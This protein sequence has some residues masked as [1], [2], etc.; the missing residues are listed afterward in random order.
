MKSSII[1]KI[2]QKELHF[3]ISPPVPAD[4][5]GKTLIT[6]QL[7]LKFRKQKYQRLLYKLIKSMACRRSSPRFML[8]SCCYK[9]CQKHLKCTSVHPSSS[10]SETPQRCWTRQQRDIQHLELKHDAQSSIQNFKGNLLLS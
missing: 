6:L 3:S 4:I 8:C 2:F 1:S 5:A 7:F 9:C 10:Y